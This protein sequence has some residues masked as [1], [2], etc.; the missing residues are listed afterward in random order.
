MT[1]MLGAGIRMGNDG[2]AVRLH[3]SAK[4]LFAFDN[5]A[6]KG[7]FSVSCMPLM[8]VAFL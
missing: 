7:H 2:R 6:G 8:P 4:G 3:Y 1:Q 5:M